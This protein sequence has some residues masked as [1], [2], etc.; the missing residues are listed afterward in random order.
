MRISYDTRSPVYCPVH[1]SVYFD[2]VRDYERRHNPRAQNNYK[3]TPRERGIRL[4]NERRE[5]EHTRL[6]ILCFPSFIA[7]VEDM[8]HQE[9]EHERA[10]RAAARGERG[11]REYET[12]QRAVARVEPGVQ[13]HAT[14]QQ[15]AARMEP[16]V[17]EHERA[18]QV[19][20]REGQV[21]QNTGQHNKQ[22]QER[23]LVA[24]Q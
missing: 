23:I 10:Q 15:S 7:E 9:H 2:F 24:H 3:E 6:Q 21:F 20:A 14:A 8:T 16:G 5:R 11:I 22:Q 13:E 17:R 1:N 12:A 19:V 4:L 18:Q